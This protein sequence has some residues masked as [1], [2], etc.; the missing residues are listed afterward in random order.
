MMAFGLGDRANPIREGKRPREI[1]KLEDA[2][3]AYTDGEDVTRYTVPYKIN[4]QY[5][6]ASGGTATGFD[7]RLTPLPARIAATNQYVQA[8]K[9]RG[10]FF[11]GSTVAQEGDVSRRYRP[12][13]R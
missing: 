4:S 3:D 7:T 11:A 1:G 5:W 9:C 6:R 2:L 13:C 8:W 12:P 10:Y